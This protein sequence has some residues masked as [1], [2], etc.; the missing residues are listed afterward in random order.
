M[1]K[2]DN[3][4]MFMWEDDTIIY[5]IKSSWF[6]A[7]DPYHRV[8]ELRDQIGYKKDYIGMKTLDEADKLWFYS[9]PGDHMSGYDKYIPEFLLPLLMHQAPVPS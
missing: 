9:G 2:L 5:P 8:E 7:F 4:G 3:F 6:G 1:E